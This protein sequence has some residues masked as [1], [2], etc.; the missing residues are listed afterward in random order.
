[1]LEKQY[2]IIIIG[3]SFT[4]PLMALSLI[5]KNPTLKICL[6]DKDKVKDKK[7]GESTS[8]ITAIYLNR[9]GI[10]EALSDQVKKTGL[11][12]LF[13]NNNEFSSPTQKSIANGY[14]L[15]RKSFDKKM[16]DKIKH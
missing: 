12:F 16:I 2:D 10:D 8:D 5:N 11:R 15:N 9:L 13:K 6:V 14:H 7:V 3:A 1:M 4:G